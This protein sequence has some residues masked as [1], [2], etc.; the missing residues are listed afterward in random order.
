MT[1]EEK[2]AAIDAVLDRIVAATE[3]KAP[4][5]VLKPLWEERLAAFAAFTSEESARW[6]SEWEADFKAAMEHLSKLWQ[7]QRGKQ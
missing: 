2:K 6:G 4:V 3:A 1:Y 5:S 7:Q